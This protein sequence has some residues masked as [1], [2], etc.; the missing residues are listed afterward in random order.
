MNLLIAMV[1]SVSWPVSMNSG[2]QE[3]KIHLDEWGASAGKGLLP[4]AHPL[5]QAGSKNIYQQ[6][7]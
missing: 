3:D 7:G 4:G 1:P 6:P 5:P 2:D